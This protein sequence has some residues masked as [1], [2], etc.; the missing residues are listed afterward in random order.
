MAGSAPEQIAHN[1]R[2]VSLWVMF[3]QVYDV[4]TGTNP[5]E[6]RLREDEFIHVAKLAIER[7]QE[8]RSRTKL[9]NSV[10]ELIRDDRGE[11]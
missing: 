10:D 5:E 9:I 2:L 3:N 4:H 11:L 1:D 7:I 8:N 6:F